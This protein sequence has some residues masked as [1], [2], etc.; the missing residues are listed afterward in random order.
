MVAMVI[1]IVVIV[2]MNTMKRN[3]MKENEVIIP[4]RRAWGLLLLVL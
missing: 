4:I 3:I 1:P 2:E